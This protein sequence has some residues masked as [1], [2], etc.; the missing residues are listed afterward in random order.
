MMKMRRRKK[1]VDEG[2]KEEANSFS[3]GNSLKSATIVIVRT[4]VRALA[5]L[6]CARSPQH[7][8]NI[9]EMKNV[10]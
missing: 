5:M 4:C 6:L 9:V 8:L 1:R 2:G 3:F 7:A 10:H